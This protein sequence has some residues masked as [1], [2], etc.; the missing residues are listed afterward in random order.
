MERQS[1]TR[2][3]PTWP[4]RGASEG[5]DEGAE[6]GLNTLGRSEGSI[7][8]FKN[9]Y[10]EEDD[11]GGGRLDWDSAACFLRFLTTSANA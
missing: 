6:P 11:G 8:C 5:V 1:W 4:T 3:W 10:L 2:S 9:Y 7:L